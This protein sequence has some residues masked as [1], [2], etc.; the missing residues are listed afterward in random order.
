MATIADDVVGGFNTFLK[1]Q[2]EDSSEARLTLVQFDGQDPFEILVD[3]ED[4]ASVEDLDPRRYQ[5]RGDTPLLDAAGAMV[6]RIDAE[7]VARADQGLPIEDQVV[8][9]IT[10]G[11]E[12]ASRE[13]SGQMISDLV[14]AR[15]ERAWTF[16]FLGAD[17]VSIRDSVAMGVASGSTTSDRYV[18]V[19]LHSVA[20]E[21]TGGLR[22]AAHE[23]RAVLRG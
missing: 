23:V 1:G 21:Q 16:V 13:F 4:L 19:S 14:S 6:A 9:I 12:N 3:G 18:P 2:R 8:V 20:G 5:P 7:I 11:F 17:E 22:R 10:D 15:R